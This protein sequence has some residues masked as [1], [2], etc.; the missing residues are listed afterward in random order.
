MKKLNLIVVLL[1]VLLLS[2][3]AKDFEEMTVAERIEAATDLSGITAC[4]EDIKSSNYTQEEQ[5][6]LFEK[7]KAFLFAEGKLNGTYYFNYQATDW[8]AW[9][10]SVVLYSVSGDEIYLMP[11]EDAP[12]N[13]EDIPGMGNAEEYRYEAVRFNDAGW[14]DD[15]R[16][17][18][19]IGFFLRRCGLDRH[20]MKVDYYAESELLRIS[21]DLPQEPEYLE[22]GT[23]DYYSDSA[24]SL[25]TSRAEY[26][27]R[28]AEA[29]ARVE[30]EIEAEKAAKELAKSEPKI[31]MTKEDV[32]KC[33]WGTPNKKNVD[34]YAWGTHEQ[35]V[36]DSKGYVYFENGVVTSVSK[37]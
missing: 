16:S 36:Y 4:I 32:E 27:K 2:G 14:Y 19:C 8:T 29:V 20:T 7:I 3:C 35:W 25:A 28:R 6:A 13:M 15:E 21:G 22:V 34:T 26:D 18:Y 24:T 17:E 31:G 30:A 5:D 11:A 23:K 37:R 12:E 10:Y 9:S 33:A 1:C